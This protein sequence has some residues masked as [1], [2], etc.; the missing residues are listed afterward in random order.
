[1][2]KPLLYED[3]FLSFYGDDLTGS[4]DV[5]ESLALNGIATALFLDLPE[6]EEVAQFRLKVGVGTSE[7]SVHLK[8]YGVAG[9][10]RSWSPEKMRK[11]LPIVFERLTRIPTDFFQY[12]VCSTFDSSPTTGNIGCAASIALEYFPSDYIPLIIGAPFLN[13]FVVFG[14][15]FARINDITYRI[16]RHPTMSKHPVTPMNESD[17]RIHLRRQTEKNVHLIDHFA[18][19]EEKNISGEHL[20]QIAGRRGDFLLFDTLTVEHLNTI[21]QTLI[22]NKPNNTQFFVGASGA[23]YALAFHLQKMGKI[24]KV[25]KVP[26]PGRADKM[27]I[28]SGSCSPVTA[29]QI[30]HMEKLGHQA[31]RIDTSRLIDP[32]QREDEIKAL[33]NRAGTIFSNNKVPLFYTAKGPDDPMIR[34]T[35]KLAVENNSFNEMMAGAQAQVIKRLFDE[36]GKMRVVVVGGDTSGYVSRAL[37]IYALETLCPIS[38]GAPLCVAHSKNNRFD[39]IEIALKGGQNGDKKYFEAVYEGKTLA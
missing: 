19:E 28:T 21:G 35:K 3:I 6:P 14:N 1:M 31:V 38:P 10:A 26:A 39:G 25:E 12:K 5:M 30:D 34:K 11:T 2:D 17:L 36:F 22:E 9:L 32:S 8:A 27:V 4:T 29:G 13:R 20:L 7:D 16:D 37:G 33:H 15:L 24:K 23:D 18:L